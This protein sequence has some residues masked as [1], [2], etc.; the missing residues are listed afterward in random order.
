MLNS[1]LT[2]NLDITTLKDEIVDEIANTM[3]DELDSNTKQNFDINSMKTQLKKNIYPIIERFGTK[4]ETNIKS[5]VETYNN[6]V[7]VELK[8]WFKT[9]LI[10]VL[11]SG[12]PVLNDGG[13]SLKSTMISTANTIT[14]N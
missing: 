2:I 5:Q 12:V 8:E 13:T 4:C 14:T 1:S 7:A 6:N 11:T 3:W 9:N 10:A